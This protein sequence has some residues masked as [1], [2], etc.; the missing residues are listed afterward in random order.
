MFHYQAKLIRVIDGD[1]IEADVDLGFH[2]WTKRTIRL[3]GIDTPEIRTKDLEEKK[4][5]IA[6][7]DFVLDWFTNNGAR[8]ILK[9]QDLDKYGRCLG[10]VTSVDESINELNTTLLKTGHAKPYK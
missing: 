2:T 7:R 4:K 9:S 5:G 10:L 6:A 8:F 3:F 1:T